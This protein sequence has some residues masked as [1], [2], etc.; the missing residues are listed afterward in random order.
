MH[1]RT[2]TRWRAAALGVGLLLA[3]T[4]TAEGCGLEPDDGGRVAAVVD[5]ETLRLEDGTELRLIGALP[6][7]R[8]ASGT[9]YAPSLGAQARRWLRRRA[10]GREVALA[11][12]AADRR[13]RRLAQVFL[14]DPDGTW[15]QE[16]LVE[17]GLAVA[18][19]FAGHSACMAALLARERA[20]R[21]AGRGLWAHG[22]LV[23]PADQPEALNRLTG[24]FVI[25]EGRVVSIGERRLRTYIDFGTY[26]SRDF[27]V[28]VGG[29][30]RDAFAEAGME[31]SAL[32]DRRIRVRGWIEAE[33]GPT[34]VA[35]HPEQIEIVADR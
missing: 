15:L 3:A 2:P 22:D 11:G 12:S 28:V 1:G 32:A 9:G 21:A 17:R 30:D 16:A 31:L 4:A 35:T 29:R 25:A 27:T 5:A 18:Y 33:T 26:W 23:R 13:G 20:A 7:G 34:V 14:A 8:A 10:V 19:S 6:P 24:D